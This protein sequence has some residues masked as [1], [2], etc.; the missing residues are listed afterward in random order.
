MNGEPHV[1]LVGMMGSGKSTV[2]FWLAQSEGLRFVDLDVAIAERHGRSIPEIFAGDGE[3][4]FRTL[5]QA[6]L[7]ECLASPQPLVL[8]C[9]GGVVLRDENRAR[10]RGRA[11][12]CWLRAGV[13]TLVRRVGGGANRPLLGGDPAAD[14]GAIHAVRADLYAETAHDIVDVDDL[15]AHQ[16]AER[17]RQLR[18]RPAAVR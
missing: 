14:L 16:V 9:G 3:D 10:L 7:A 2:G 8:A 18:P 12:V 5:E 4:G 15:S 11:W 1:A 17:V 13:D 6:E